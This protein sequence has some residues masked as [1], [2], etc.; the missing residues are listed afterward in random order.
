M[1]SFGKKSKKQLSTVSP[2]LQRVLQDAIKFVDF[3]IIEGHRSIDRQKE[4]FKEGVTQID[5]EKDLSYHNARPSLAVDIIPYK[6]G[7]NPFDGSEESEFLFLKLSRQI[8]ISAKKCKVNIYW[9]GHWVNFND[10]PHWEL[11]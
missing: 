11:H 8:F 9:G 3:S 6:K 1:Y 2:D 5:G 7:L 4:L 10:L